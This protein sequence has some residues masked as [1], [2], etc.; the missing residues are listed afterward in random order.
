MRLR[1]GACARRLAAWTAACLVGAALAWAGCSPDDPLAEALLQQD[2]AW[3]CGELTYQSFGADF[4]ARYCLACHNE[5]LV[6]D[7]ARSDAPTD[8]NFNRL[9]GI[10]A[11]QKRIRMRA[12]VQGDMP[13]LLLAVPRPGEQ[14][15]VQLIQ[16]IDCGAPSESD[17]ATP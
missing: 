13:P 12:G 15:R 7:L 9:D 6:G 4:F 1:G 2:R 11:F 8:I 3:P 16:W 14:E 17:L 10:R 5:L